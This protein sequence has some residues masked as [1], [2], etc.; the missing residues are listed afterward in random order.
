[1]LNNNVLNNNLFQNIYSAGNLQALQLTQ[2]DGHE[3]IA[4][5]TD[6]S[7]K[8]WRLVKSCHDASTEVPD[9]NNVSITDYWNHEVTGSN[10]KIFIYVVEGIKKPRNEKEYP[11]SVMYC[12]FST[13]NNRA[14]TPQMIT[15]AE[16]LMANVY[17][18][19]LTDTRISKLK[20]LT[21]NIVKKPDAK[22]QRPALIKLEDFDD[23][24]GRKPK[25]AAAEK[26]EVV[27]D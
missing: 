9:I 23:S 10:N 3:P 2:I 26:K 4:G 18:G 12:W 22:P 19:N 16:W 5:F 15:P 25:Q 24:K 20:Y 11:C 7:G 13:V 8:E 14:F 17:A 21:D 6:S 27:N 1:M